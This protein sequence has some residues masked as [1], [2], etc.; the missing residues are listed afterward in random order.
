MTD[1]DLHAK[2]RLGFEASVPNPTLAIMGSTM[3]I[4]GVAS[5][6]EPTNNTQAKEN[7]RTKLADGTSVSGA[8]NGSAASFEDD[9][10]AQ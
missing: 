5:A 1:A 7:N 3:Q 10:R 2:R 8:T 9:R 4:D 6:V